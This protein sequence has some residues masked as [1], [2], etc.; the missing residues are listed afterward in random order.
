MN[1]LSEIDSVDSLSHDIQTVSI[2]TPILPLNDLVDS[3][4]TAQL[5]EYRA[6][7]P[8]YSVFNFST[9]AFLSYYQ[10]SLS[11]TVLHFTHWFLLLLVHL[12][13][14]LSP[15]SRKTF[16]SHKQSLSIQLLNVIK[17]MTVSA[18]S[19]ITLSYPHTFSLLFFNPFD[20]EMRLAPLRSAL[21]GWMPKCSSF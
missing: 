2:F 18:S 19:I 5:Y 17:T 1:G 3:K 9:H 4:Q 10:F 20:S 12:G 6:Q 21:L 13:W 14:R 11:H 8:I 15:V 16:S 7:R